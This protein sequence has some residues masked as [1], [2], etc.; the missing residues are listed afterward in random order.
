M[1][2]RSSFP[3]YCISN[4][5]VYITAEELFDLLV[6]RF[7]LP[8]LRTPSPLDNQNYA[9]AIVYPMRNRVAEFLRKWLRKH[10]Y[11][12][13]GN[14]ALKE[15]ALRFYRDVRPLHPIR[16]VIRIYSF[17]RMKTR[18]VEDVVKALKFGLA[19]KAIFR[20]QDPPESFFKE[21]FGVRARLP[22]FLLIS[23]DK[24]A[25]DSTIMDFDAEE[26][27]RQ[28]CLADHELFVKVRSFVV[29]PF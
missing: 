18:V 23:T 15:R 17:Q 11:D 2:V 27:A 28:I 12:I 9:D 22:S 8:T 6:S 7:E 3:L 16:L 4:G 24:A 29:F 13:L 14:R 25:A 1:D 19:D 20:P 10:P 21:N 26:V 5:L